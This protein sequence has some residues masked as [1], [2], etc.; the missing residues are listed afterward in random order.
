MKLIR[1]V[2]C[3]TKWF[4]LLGQ[5]CYSTFLDTSATSGSF[6]RL[7]KSLKYVPCAL[8]LT[9]TTVLTVLSVHFSIYQQNFGSKTGYTLYIVGA[10]NSVTIVFTSLFTSIVHFDSFRLLFMQVNDME[11]AIKKD[12]KLDYQAF[13]R[14]FLKKMLIICISTF[15]PIAVVMWLK[16]PTWKL[17]YFTFILLRALAALS[18]IHCLFYICLYD[19]LLKSFV[20][21]VDE[22]GTNTLLSMSVHIRDA[23]FLKNEFNHY[24]M[25]H[26]KL[27]TIGKTIKQ[28]FGWP[29]T[30]ILFQSFIY[31]LFSMYYTLIVSFAK[32]FDTDMLRKFSECSLMI[33]GKSHLPNVSVHR[34]GPAGNFVAMLVSVVILINT[35][36]YCTVSVNSAPKNVLLLPV[37][38][39]LLSH[40]HI[41]ENRFGEKYWKDAV[42]AYRRHKNSIC[43]RWTL[44]AGQILGPVDYCKRI[45][46]HQP[47]IDGQCNVFLILSIKRILA[48][49][50]NVFFYL[51][52]A[53]ALCTYVVI[54]F[55]FHVDAI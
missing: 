10:I 51:Q 7:H 45:C 44:V 28:I 23:K 34:S 46:Y 29:L 39:R 31:A 54:F 4:H 40:F 25:L 35:C 1:T 37:N 43:K 16:V 30:V 53:T 20:K 38:I 22:R 48:K 13:R 6:H 55:Q 41:S 50:K 27:W 8:M 26:F 19:F 15:V 12:F 5:G 36:H 32:G 42:L 33:Q 21:Y 49:T 9:L 11:Q 52:L 24:K 2:C 47:T 17:P 3:F 18:I 14:Y